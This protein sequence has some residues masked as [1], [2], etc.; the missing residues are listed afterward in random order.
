MRW[1]PTLAHQHLVVAIRGTRPRTVT[2]SSCD[3][4]TAEFGIAGT[5]ER[6]GIP[7]PWRRCESYIDLTG[8]GED[9]VRAWMHVHID[10]L[11]TRRPTD[12]PVSGLI[13][14]IWDGLDLYGRPT[15]T[16]VDVIAPTTHFG[17]TSRL[18]ILGSA[19]RDPRRRTSTGA[20]GVVRAT[21]AWEDATPIRWDTP[22]IQR[23]FELVVPLIAEA[24]W[25]SD[26]ESEQA[27]AIHPFKSLEDPALNIGVELPRWGIDD[28]AWIV[29]LT[30]VILSRAGVA[31]DVQVSVRRHSTSKL[32]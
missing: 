13:R 4:E 19:V 2:Q 10:E 8:P 1:R 32:T 24:G 16:G 14:A 6:W 9:V 15:L 30:Y 5:L 11:D 7:P 31:E 22:G 27:S 28:L 25:V 20:K 29:E 3:E 17:E 21:A 23:E 18:R 12:V 26:I